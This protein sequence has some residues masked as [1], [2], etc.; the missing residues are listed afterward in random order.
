MKNLSMYRWSPRQVGL[1]TVLTACL[2][3]AVLFAGMCCDPVPDD[4]GCS[5]CVQI[6]FDPPGYVHAGSMIAA[7]CRS[8]SEPFSCSESSTIC[9]TLPGATLFSDAECTEIAGTTTVTLYLPMCSG[10]DDS[11]NGG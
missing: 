1:A 11:C 9:A 3:P 4:P 6:E 2:P 5:G 8:S 10:K 7:R